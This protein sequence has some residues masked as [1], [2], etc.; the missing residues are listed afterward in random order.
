MARGRKATG[1]EVAT[2]C[3]G[4]RL[5]WSL[6]KST[7]ASSGRS[8][9]GAATTCGIARSARTGGWRLLSRLRLP[10]RSVGLHER[11]EESF[12]IDQ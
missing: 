7:C 12:R 11:A 3:N 1:D 9:S 5:L 10:L 2:L 6:T 4:E 8:L